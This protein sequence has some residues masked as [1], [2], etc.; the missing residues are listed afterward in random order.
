MNHRLAALLTA[1]IVVPAALPRVALF[2]QSPDA[3]ASTLSR[4]VDDSAVAVAHID[5]ARVDVAS[6]AKDLAR[7]AESGG[8]PVDLP[9]LELLA[10]QSQSLKEAGVTS[11]YAVFAAASLGDDN[12]YYV[13]LLEPG[14]NAA[15]VAEF[16]KQK[17]A[18]PTGV[19]VISSNRSS[20]AAVAAIGDAVVAGSES[21]VAR[22]K[23]SAP[24]P[25]PEL[26][27]ALTAAA[28]MPVA[29][30]LVPSADQRKA[31]EETLPTLPPDMGGG[32]TL[33]LTRGLLWGAIGYSPQDKAWNVVIQSEN[34]AAATAFQKGLRDLPSRFAHV[35]WMK[36]VFP[37][38]R[39]PDSLVPAVT[40]DLL[41][42]TV[43]QS[44]PGAVALE[45]TL[46]EAGKVVRATLWKTTRRD[47]LKQLA[48]A[49]HN[50]L[51]AHGR[52]PAQAIYDK[53]GRALLSWRV[54]LLPF[55]GENEL[56]K[57]FHL[58]EAWDSEHNQKLIA[59]IPALFRTPE[60]L[61][62]DREKT[63]MLGPVGKRAF[64]QGKQGLTI[65]DIT[66]GTSNTIMILEATPADA[67][68]WTKP[69]DFNVDFGHLHERLFQ[70][71]DSFG[72]AFCD[73][74]YHLLQH[75]MKEK[76]LQW[77]FSINGG[78]IIPQF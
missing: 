55:L 25:R 63:T 44:D 22:L 18:N 4:C 3:I 72:T 28:S 21:V 6:A 47:Y 62:R 71:R 69:D 57:E 66:D 61:S 1:A 50:F 12:P 34:A 49:T 70:G 2:A 64:F 38:G 40:N 20:F 76:T 58:D 35:A 37:E 54:Q 8:I 51:D 74:A 16:V 53:N 46:S 59:R 42:L 52:F 32:S 67:V 41:K 75:A 48:L 27:G 30:L 39:L 31:L 45:Q 9:A 43:K 7:A 14:R 73:G 78:E 26:K 36:S 15:S 23:G 17:I 13:A 56:Y 10:G 77:L 11:V 5:F 65:R 24:A 33:V 68:I 29:F 60:L 19:F